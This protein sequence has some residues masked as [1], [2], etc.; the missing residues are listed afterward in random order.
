MKPSYLGGVL[1]LFLLPSAYML[2]TGD[3]RPLDKSLYSPS[4]KS[5]EEP[6]EEPHWSYKGSD[7]P[8]EW[9]HLHPSFAMCDHGHFQSPIDLEEGQK[10]S[11]V[12]DIQFN[13]ED[14][15][16]S[17][18]DNGH[19]V[20]VVPQGRN[21]IKL[22]GV[23]Y[24]LTQLH[25]HT[26]SEHALGHT[27]HIM[28]AHLVHKNDEGELAVVGVLIDEGA[29][30]EI[31]DPCFDHIPEKG[32]SPDRVTHFDPSWLLPKNVKHFRYYGSL[33]TPPCSEGVLWTVME[34]PIT[35]S[36]TQIAAFKQHYTSNSRPLQPHIQWCDGTKSIARN[37]Q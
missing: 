35:L 31:L 21:S 23:T 13:Y 7:G 15:V 29:G 18:I 30:T 36:K 20:L 25:F 24:R 34:Q 22:D 17:I 9:G 3:F 11:T 28:E 5:P 16:A 14:G 32:E 12:D 27:R 1:L 33:T 10:S 8:N 26:P 2:S 19:T 37:T 6:K 4:I